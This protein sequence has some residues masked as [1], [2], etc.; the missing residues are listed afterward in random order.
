MNMNVQPEII[1]KLEDKAVEMLRDRQILSQDSDKKDINTATVK[2]IKSRRN[3]P[4]KRFRLFNGKSLQYIEQVKSNSSNIPSALVRY[5]DLT[6]DSKVPLGI[7]YL[8]L[9]CISDKNDFYNDPRD[10]SQMLSMISQEMGN[11]VPIDVVE[12]I[13]YVKSQYPSLYQLDLQLFDRYESH[14]VNFIT[15]LAAEPQNNTVDKGNGADLKPISIPVEQPPIF[16]IHQQAVNSK[17]DLAQNNNN[18]I[19]IFIILLFGVMMLVISIFLLQSK[20]KNI[21]VKK[22]Y[23]TQTASLSNHISQAEAL[24]IVDKWFQSKKY[25]FAPPYDQHL[26]ASLMTGKALSDN[27]KGS[28]TDGSAES[29]LEWLRNRKKYW[30]Y[31]KWKVVAKNFT[32]NDRESVITVAV[33]E[34]RTLYNKDESKEPNITT[35]NS[36]IVFTLVRTADGIKISNME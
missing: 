7:R 32:S 3:V 29:Y 1:K 36:Q 19:L 22:N 8:A 28:K 26:G 13:Q 25:L 31:G 33:T 15:R 27:I 4:A 9:H 16:S 10:K 20:Y 17:P 23:L 30:E 5:N 24:E 35:S 6:K 2:L 12:A 34:E 14:A 21:A 11:L 18:K